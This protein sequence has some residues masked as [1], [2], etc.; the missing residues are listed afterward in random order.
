MTRQVQMQRL[1]QVAAL[2]FDSKLI[3]LRAAARAMQETRDHLA[4]LAV[5]PADPDGLP[6]IALAVAAL[7]Y[8]RWADTRRA[9]LN[10]T[11]A[12]Q[13]ATWLDAQGAARLAFGKTQALAA[14]TAKLRA[15]MPRTPR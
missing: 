4:D 1:Q 14:V 7:H 12:R 10:L 11:L 6:Q 13:T 3:D 15:A 8:D 5:S 2:M 9:E